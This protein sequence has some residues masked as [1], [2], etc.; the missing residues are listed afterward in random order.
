MTTLCSTCGFNNPPGMRFCGNC[1][2]RLAD[3]APATETTASQDRLATDG[4][5]VLMGADLADRL[6]R[7]GLEATGQRRNVTVLFTDLSGFTAL[8]ERIDG[9][10]LYDIIQQY[11]RV[12][13]N[14]VYKYEGI[15]DKLTGDGLMALFGAPIAHENNAERAVL[16]ALDMQDDLDEI[17]RDM[18]KR[19]GIELQMHIGLHSGSVIVG[20]IGSDL[21]MNYTAIGDTV[22]LARRIEEAAPADSILISDAV[23]RQVRALF[24]CQQVSVLNPKGIAHPVVAFRVSGRRVKPGMVRG[25]DGLRAP[26]IGRDHELA[27]LKERENSLLDTRQ[28]QFVVVTGEA[29]LGKSRLTN[30]FK[31]SLDLESV[32]ILEGQSLVYRRSIPYWIFRD[33]IH[34]YLDVTVGMSTDEVSERLQQRLYQALG[35]QADEAVPYFEHM[36][37]LPYSDA[38]TAERLRY[39][40]GGQLRQ[41]I[42][43]AVRDL[44]LVDAYNRPLV[45]VLEDLHWADEASLEL[46][47]FLVE[48]LRYAPIFILAISRSIQPG[49]L[50]KAVAWGKQNISERCVTIPVQQLSLVQSKQLLY[51]LL[52]ISEL[53][54]NMGEQ[55]LQRAAGI[56]FYLEEILRMLIDEGALRQEF[57]RW[58]VVPDIDI[59]ALGVPET[60]QGLIMARFDRLE[61]SQRHILQIASVVGKDFNEAVLNTVLE[62]SDLGY[63]RHL[64]EELVDREFIVPRGVTTNGEYTFRHILMSDAIYGTLLRKERSQLHGQVGEAIEKIY[65]DRIEEQIEL[66]ANHYRW[67]NHLDRALH[68]LILAGQKA[69]RNNVHEQAQQQFAA[70]LE[71][72]PKVEHLPYQE[73]Q[74]YGGLGDALSFAGDYSAARDRFQDALRAIVDVDPDLYVEECSSLYRR[75]ARTFERQGEYDQALAHLSMAQMALDYSMLL[76]PVERSQ[77]WHDIGWIHF[78]RGNIPEA[79][80]HLS[81]ALNLVENSEAYDVVASIYNRLA[82]VAYNQGDWDSAASY[83]RKSI[84]L[85]EAIRDVVGLASSL[86]NL[87]YMEI[88]MGAFDSAL[89]TLSRSYELKKRLGNADGI[90]VSLNNLG[91]L[92]TARGDLEE[93]EE[94]LNSALELAIQIGYLSLIRQ[95]RKNIGELHLNAYHWEEARHVLI[96]TV[97]ALKEANVQDQLVDTYRLL[98]EAELGLDDLDAAQGWLRAIDTL[99][100]NWEQKEELSAVHRGELLRFRGMLAARLHEWDAA[101]QHLQESLLVFQKLRSRLYQGRVIYQLGLLAEMQSKSS[102]A[103]AHFNRAV[104]LF[105]SVGAKLDEQRAADALD[106]QQ[107]S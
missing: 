92:R 63:L 90:G 14:D 16:S 93:A 105:H 31:T 103:Q 58:Q 39:L 62:F 7:A 78:R 97:D 87:G 69:A 45:L 68:Y 43:L 59:S 12:M 34:N 26:M 49:P 18:K 106:R 71:L 96:E 99:M 17:N 86:N 82:G 104:G 60:L 3:A 36:L 61:S 66:L 1:G 6:R 67:S 52:S 25:V 11:I 33:V 4:L 2:A 47:Y 29:G 107:V 56:P 95:T 64:L 38:R 76:Y 40:D 75:V 57:G 84:A 20:G 89:D 42:F 70:A 23:Y 41:Q 28:G 19:L 9:E 72:L 94:D 37:S 13:S 5:G 24:D 74:I 80:Q 85:R 50:E 32:R 102:E 46:L 22:N 77:V 79:Q 55:I 15:V 81:E 54:G 98:G 44:L 83:L 51:Q 35:N 53:P 101:S 30:E 48:V 73:L 27:Q 88:E 21:L 100:A 65:A 10:D 8:S 91:W